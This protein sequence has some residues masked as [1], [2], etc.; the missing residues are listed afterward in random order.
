MIRNA[1]CSL[2]VLLSFGILQAQEAVNQVDQNG[3]RHGVWKKYFPNSKQLRYTGTF[4]HGKE[5]GTFNFYCEDCKEQP[6]IVKEFSSTDNTALVTYYDKKGRVISKGTME[7]KVRIGKWVYFHKGSDQL[8]LEEHYTQGQLNGL[9]TTYYE[10]GNKTEELMYQDGLRHG[11]NKYYSPSGVLIK[12][13]NYTEDKLQGPAA[14]CD[15]KGNLII[16]GQ[17]KN[18][19]KDGMWYYYKNGKLEREERFPR[20][21]KKQ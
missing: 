3:E 12:D 6:A 13:L 16:K 2:V 14:Y 10:N 7:G 18:D 11:I 20:Q 19:A 8:M 5:V 9:K 1:V 21:N 4:E 17:Y 15:A